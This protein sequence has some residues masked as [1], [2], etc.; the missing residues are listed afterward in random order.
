[1]TYAQ[2][3]EDERTG[4]VSSAPDRTRWKRIVTIGTGG[5]LLLIG[6][7][8]RS[9][10][11]ATLALLGG[12]LCYRGIVNRSDGQHDLERLGTSLD[13]AEASAGGR[14]VERSITVGTS[15]AE[16]FER[17]I[18]PSTVTQVFGP[19]VEISPEESTVW[20]WRIDGPFG[21]H[22]TWRTEVVESEPGEFLRW[23]T[24]DDALVD[25]WGTVRF[26]RAPG[27]RGTEVTL[28]LNVDPP[29]GALG[30]M[31]V[32]RAG[33]IPEI[34]A[35]KALR[36]FKSLVETGEVPTLERNPSARGRGDLL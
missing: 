10:G 18:E 6:L 22:R 1:M 26:R 23:E 4:V 13:R 12:F 35:T 25:G 16:L 2:T 9:T 27:E 20:T 11:G 33:F 32:E 34:L 28:R 19:V 17:W 5:G 36:R 31:L 29:G 21:W 8:K 14:T 7:R 30:N 15:A 24:H 3:V